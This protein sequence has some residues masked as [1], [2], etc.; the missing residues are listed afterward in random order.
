MANG[1]TKK[2]LTRAREST[3]KQRGKTSG[4]QSQSTH[5]GHDHLHLIDS[6]TRPFPLSDAITSVD[7]TTWG[8][9]CQM[10]QQGRMIDGLGLTLLLWSQREEEW[11]ERVKI[12]QDGGCDR[13]FDVLAPGLSTT[14]GGRI[15]TPGGEKL[16]ENASR[17]SRR[18]SADY[19]KEARILS[20]KTSG[21]GGNGQ[22]D[23]R[24]EA[25]GPEGLSGPSQDG[26]TSEGQ[27]LR[28]RLLQDEEATAS[29]PKQVQSLA[30]RGK[31][32]NRRKAL[33]KEQTTP[34]IAGRSDRDLLST[35]SHSSRSQARTSHDNPARQPR[36]NMDL[37]EGLGRDNSGHRNRG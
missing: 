26:G 7:L 37:T 28:K 11:R 8:T 25:H 35:T 10:S 22:E 4:A 12:W 36:P 16:L 23:G 6:Q 3:D 14:E 5:Q 33:G 9:K 30:D 1:E 21:E 29:V 18:R 34:F 17:D 32:R 31:R 2:R 19:W 24:A 27:C 15:N 13:I 20:E